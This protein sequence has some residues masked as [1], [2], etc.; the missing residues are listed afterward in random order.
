MTRRWLSTLRHVVAGNGVDYG[1]TSWDQVKQLD[2]SGKVTIV[3][4]YRWQDIQPVIKLM[5]EC[6]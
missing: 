6:S 5:L 2:Q 1:T 3:K 4:D